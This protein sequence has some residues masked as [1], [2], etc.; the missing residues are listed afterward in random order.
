LSFASNYFDLKL[1]IDPLPLLTNQA[2]GEHFMRKLNWLTLALIG[3]VAMGTAI[4]AFAHH[5]FAAEFDINKP[6]TLDG[7]VTKFEWSNPHIYVFID[8]KDKQGRI[9]NW[10]VESASPGQLARRGWKNDTV[11]AGDHILADGFAAKDGS[12]L[13]G[14]RNVTFSDGR[15]IF[16]GAT[17]DGGPGDN[18]NQ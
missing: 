4:P 10:G 5:S 8:V 7:V 15:K 1:A 6:V 3:G 18:G 14:A 13:V 11:K 12:K 17:G 9:T 2:Y 16:A